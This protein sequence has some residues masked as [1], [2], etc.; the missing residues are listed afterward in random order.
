MIPCNPLHPSSVLLVVLALTPGPPAQA[1][2]HRITTE[3]SGARVSMEIPLTAYARNPATMVVR[4]EPTGD[5]AAP[6]RLRTRLG[7]P[8]HGH[9]VGDEQSHPEGEATIRHDGA[10][11]MDGRYRLRIWLDYPDGAVIRTGA[12]FELSGEQVSVPV[13]AP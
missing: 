13:A 8:D 11:P 12:D 4:V 3:V 9:W 1:E 2:S 5:G 7:M 6:R 10:L